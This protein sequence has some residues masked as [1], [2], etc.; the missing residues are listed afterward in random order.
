LK[1]APDHPIPVI[2][3]YIFNYGQ[4]IN[5]NLITSSEQ[6]TQIKNLG[7]EQDA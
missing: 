5:K 7:E 1:Y 3:G 4:Q 2:D 6:E